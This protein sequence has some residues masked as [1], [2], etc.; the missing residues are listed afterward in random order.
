ME[1]PT[2]PKAYSLDLRTRVLNDCDAGMNSEEAAEK[3][4]VSASWVYDLRKKR[5]ETGSI[6]PK[7]Y[8]PGPKLKLA[9]YEQEVR[10][11]VADHPDA[12]LEELH[13]MLPNREDVTCVTL[14]NFLKR[15]KITWKKRLSMLPNNIE[16]KSRKSVHNG[17]HYKKRSR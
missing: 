17:K 12:T 10:Q 4:S 9:P 11:L 13:A 1:E 16:K 6:A 3:Y 14:H 15:L 8:Q 5:R 2:M 7:K